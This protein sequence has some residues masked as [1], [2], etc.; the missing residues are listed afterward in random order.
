VAGHALQ[1][2]ACDLAGALSCD[3]CL[4]RCCSSCKEGRLSWLPVIGV[5]MFGKADALLL[6]VV[7]VE[8]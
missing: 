5:G 2:L 8:R 6:R 4:V 3:I 1:Q 7:Q